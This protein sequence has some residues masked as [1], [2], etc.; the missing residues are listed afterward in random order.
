MENETGSV[1]TPG[2][3]IVA[4]LKIRGWNQEDLARIINRPSPRITGLIQ[5][6]IPISPD[7]AV[8]LGT[9]FGNAPEEWLRREAAYRLS[10]TE[11]N[12]DEVKRRA[13]VYGMAPIKEMK[14]RGWISSTDDVDELEKELKAFFD[15]SDLSQE[16]DFAANF[17]KSDRYDENTNS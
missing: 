8:M 7:W 11:V 17:R 3:Y 12:S 6:K 16:P 9:A 2:E 15:V 5:G 14:K 4:E 13:L 10:L 1:P